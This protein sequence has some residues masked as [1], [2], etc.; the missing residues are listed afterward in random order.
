MGVPT[1]TLAGNTMVARQGAS[2]LSCAGLTDWVAEDPEEYVATAAAHA[3]QVDKLALLRSGLRL[4]V[5][6]SP[7]F[8]GPRFAGN[9]EAALWEMW[10]RFEDEN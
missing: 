8:D 2:L 3:A 9:L 5:S 10:R 4:Q 1:V 7:L 6:A